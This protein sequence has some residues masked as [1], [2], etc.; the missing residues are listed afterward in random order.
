MIDPRAL[1]V[2]L[3]SQSDL[4]IEVHSRRAAGAYELTIAGTCRSV[5]EGAV[6]DLRFRR[7]VRRVDWD[8]QRLL[9]QPD[10]KAW[11]RKA[12]LDRGSFR[13]RELFP[14]PRDVEVD[15]FLLP[16]GDERAL[17]DPGARRT[18][19]LRLGTVPET[20]GALRTD[21]VR[22]DR[23]FA[24]ART[25]LDGL[26]SGKKRA[27]LER[28][29]RARAAARSDEESTQL[30]A[31]ADLLERFLADLS[32]AA[33]S[34]ARL[35]SAV[36]GAAFT[37]DSAPSVLEKIEAV[38]RRERRLILVN[39]AGRIFREI[40]RL[41]ESGDA[42][43]W[44][45]AEPS[46]EKALQS[47]ESIRERTWE[48]LTEVLADLERLFSLAPQ[49]VQCPASVGAEWEK[50]QTDLSRLVATLEQALREG[51]ERRP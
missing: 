6:A 18:S 17:P 27:L 15:L 48:G 49:R 32:G 45:R 39:E 21:V 10:E 37:L 36:T 8:T 26:R 22:M 30:P 40:T 16:P 46:L 2:L 38:G 43:A 13:H 3:M 51:P 50:I 29:E 1:V 20:I 41:A 19:I 24:E 23:A 42:R 31:T 5:P 25:I 9:T 28:A 33:G 35:V 14:S 7:L 12:S 11:G 47:V 34:E 44:S 4:S